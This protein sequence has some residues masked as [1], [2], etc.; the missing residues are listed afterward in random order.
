MDGEKAIEAL[1]ALA[2]AHRLSVFRALV[3]RAPKGMAAGDLAKALAVPP[4]SLSF[5]LGLLERAGLIRSHR[6][7][8]HIFYSLDLAGTRR[9]MAFLTED[10]C[11][12]RPEICAGLTLPEGEAAG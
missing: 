12:G 8:R 5:H 9:L 2:H 4:S 11:D 10:C 3:R 1:S 6:Q 7:S